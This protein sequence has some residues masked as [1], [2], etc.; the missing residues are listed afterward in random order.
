M[1]E[2]NKVKIAYTVVER[3][4][5]GRKFWVRVG[6]AFVNRDGSLNVRLDAMPVNGELHIRDYHQPR[7]ARDRALREQAA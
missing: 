3:N 2:E 5:D 6:A 7:E 4:K 1:L